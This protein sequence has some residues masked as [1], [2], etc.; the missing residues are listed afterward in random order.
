[1]IYDV[2]AEVLQK[3]WFVAATHRTK[4]ACMPTSPT[5]ICST[6]LAETLLLLSSLAVAVVD[7]LL[8]EE[9]SE[10]MGWISS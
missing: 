8:L 4:I 3:I 5:P 10:E 2:P 6:G 1:M 7:R 9:T